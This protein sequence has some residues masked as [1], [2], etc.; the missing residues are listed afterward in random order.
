MNVKYSHH[1]CITQLHH[2]TLVDDTSQC[3]V[4]APFLLWSDGDDTQ[5]FVNTAG[6]CR[7]WAL[8]QVWLDGDDPL[9][10]GKADRLHT[11]FQQ[12]VIDV[13]MI[14]RRLV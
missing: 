14:G 10:L 12:Q 2:S 8:L 11:S 5:I 13:H 1:T 9:V 4:W 3:H 6:K 7:A